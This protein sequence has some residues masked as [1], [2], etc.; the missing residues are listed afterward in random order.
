MT[1]RP[2]RVALLLLFLAAMGATAYLFWIA[3]REARSIDAAARTFD[4][5]AHAA[6]AQVA[7][8]RATQQAYVAAGQGQD[9]WFARAGKALD[10]LRTTITDLRATASGSSSTA[11]FDEAASALQDFEQMDKRAR[12]YVRAHQAP[13]A[14][15]LIFSDGFDLSRKMAVAIEQARLAERTVRDAQT[16]ALE[17]RE[18][19]SLG[20]AAAAG[21]LIVLLLVPA[22]GQAELT[23]LTPAERSSPAFA[24]ARPVANLGLHALDVEGWSP[25]KREKPV[26]STSDAPPE[27]VIVEPIAVAEPAPAPVA[28]VQPAP[29]PRID[30]QRVAS[31][32]TDLARV[33]DTR[34][35]PS[36]LE[37]ASEA[38]DA[39]GIV[40]WVADPDGRE[41]AAIMAHGYAPNLVVRLGTIAREAENATAAAFRTSLIQTVKADSVSNGAIAAPLIGAAGC[42]GVMAAEVRNRA[43]QDDNVLAAAG[44]IAAQL[45]TL[46]APPSSRAKAEAAG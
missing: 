29:E 34:T 26:E 2:V 30:L 25:A 3:E 1:N 42:V 20:A 7:D 14:S 37:R 10:D 46:V 36:L 45:A 13:L 27:P 16:A 11:S 5:R 4:D 28:A 22:G 8:L 12:D 31:I 24:G 43:E 21:L 18:V 32:C 40:L 17:R 41:L 35:L 19:F 33:V 23:V 9:F 39:V 6:E 15:D 38:L 44:I